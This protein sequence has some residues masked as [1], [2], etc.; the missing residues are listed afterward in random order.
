MCIRV[1]N[2]LAPIIQFKWEELM[3]ERR[4]ITGLVAESA[5]GSLT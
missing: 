3:L 1:K 4:R 5:E 2:A